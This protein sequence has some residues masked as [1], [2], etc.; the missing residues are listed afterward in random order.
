MPELFSLGLV[1][2]DFISRH[3]A[4]RPQDEDVYVLEV[5]R[6]LAWVLQ[7]VSGR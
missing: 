5:K 4:V 2:L 7:Q 1:I 3:E 6:Q